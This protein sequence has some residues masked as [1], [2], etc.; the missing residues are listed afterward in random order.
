IFH[1]A[2]RSSHQ[3]TA[4]KLGYVNSAVIKGEGGEFERNPDA[5]TL[6]CGIRDGELYELELPKLTADRSA[7]EEELN[8]DTFKE[9]W[10]GDSQHTYG[11]VAVIETMASA[12]YTMNVA[13]KFTQAQ[14]LAQEYWQSRHRV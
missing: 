13:D 3:Q 4:A 2:Y 5:K 1:P 8:L 12:L 14:T 7:I 10:L 6:I 11:E 9:I